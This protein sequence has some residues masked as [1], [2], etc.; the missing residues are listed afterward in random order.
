L[1]PLVNSPQEVSTLVFR[2]SGALLTADRL[3]TLIT[4]SD[5]LGL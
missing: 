3:L 2:R 4:D 5:W 1:L